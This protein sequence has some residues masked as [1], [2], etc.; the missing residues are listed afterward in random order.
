M[1]NTMSFASLALS[2][3]IAGCAL[4]AQPG[5]PTGAESDA[6]LAPEVCLDIYEPVCGTDG[7]TYSNDRPA[8]AGPLRALVRAEQACPTRGRWRRVGTFVERASMSRMADRSRAGPAFRR[9]A[10]ATS[11]A[12]CATSRCNG[13]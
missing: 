4:P 9:V 2:L 5:D 6:G 11:G 7:A 10:S 8:A 12:S 3:A 1:T 13:V